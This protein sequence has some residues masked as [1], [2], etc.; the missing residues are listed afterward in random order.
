MSEVAEEEIYDPW[1][2]DE[3]EWDPIIRA[4]WSFDGANTL[5]EAAE[6]LEAF[7]QF[8][9]ERHGAGWKLREPINDDYGFVYHDTLKA[10]DF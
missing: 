4:K 7:A 10:E 1:D 6:R 9:R 5:E 2:E 8:L 3:D